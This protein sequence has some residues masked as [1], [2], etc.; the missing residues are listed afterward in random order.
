MRVKILISLGILAGL[1]ILVS[2]AF[3]EKSSHRAEQTK[4][5]SQL[6][7]RRQLWESAYRHRGTQIVYPAAPE[8]IAAGYR[9]YYKSVQRNR[10]AEWFKRYVHSDAE[11]PADSLDRKPLSLVG[12]IGSNRV[13]QQLLPQLPIKL[14]EHGFRFRGQDYTAPDDILYLLN[15][16]P[17][18][19]TQLLTV[20]TGNSDS[21]ILAFLNKSS[22][23][24]RQMSEYYVAQQGRVV[25]FGFF[26]DEGEQAWQPE[27]A[28]EYDLHGHEKQ[29]EMTLHFSYVTHGKNVSE[30]EIAALA[31]RN[32][33]NLFKLMRRLRVPKAKVDLL[34]RLAVHL[35]DSAEE[36][37]MF[38]SNTDLRHLDAARH[39]AH[40][41]WLPDFRGDDFFAEANWFIQQLLGE[42]KSAALREGLTTAMSE[43]WRGCGY[44]GWAARLVQ[45][46]NAPPLAE[47]FEA[48]V[49]EAE[50]DLVRQPLL[51]SFTAYLL[52]KFGAEEFTKLYQTWPESGLPSNF[53]QNEKWENLIAAWQEKMR[54]TAATPL[55]H[56]QPPP[57][58]ASDFHRGFCYAH[59]G[60]QIYNGYL[61]HKSRE[62]LENLA[63]LGVNAI[64]VTPFGYLRQANQPDFLGRSNGPSG[65]SDE[66]LIIA[67]SF[68]KA[69]NIRV[70]L[71]PHIWV[72]RGWPGDI[73]MPAP[74]AWKIFFDRYERWMRGYAM[75]A[76]IYDFD[77]L[78]VGVELAQT[79]VGH[80]PEWRSMIKSLRELYS[81][82]MVYAANWGQEFENLAFWEA[83]EAIGIDCYYPL[84][85]EENPTD[86]ELKAGA[87]QVVK[88]IHA[89]SKKFNKPVLLT[90][91]GFCSMPQTWK[92]PHQD[93][94]GAPV[95]LEAQ[96]RCYEAISQ[97]FK[98]SMEKDGDWLAGIYWWKWPTMLEDGGPQD[99]QFTPNGK[100]AA[101]VVA[102]WY[103]LGVNAEATTGQ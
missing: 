34:P 31:E 70:M 81:G 77:V 45:T 9:E 74:A 68:A 102:R 10:D 23:R 100:P 49:W 50:S 80:A 29:A 57:I 17:Q 5:N 7:T 4:S 28:R 64:S 67:Q 101:E 15:P 39:E 89:V 96:R 46:Q 93:S 18:N 19:P 88:K 72:G 3:Q 71:K 25:R 48:N 47:L 58:T 91:I 84:S 24:L 97:A 8:T 79:T 38:T 26:Q 98:N 75:L 69:H 56:T 36:K 42:S 22:R 40:L 92:S 99:N 73:N 43:H 30:A 59:E 44:S 12:A 2:F 85:E 41:L 61:G 53:P 82:P 65:E 37:G 11:Y 14:L 33:E 6:P 62:A 86:A 16:N 13:L 35:W 87:E 95:D 54:A 83:L 78:C 21:A 63:T 27:A 55:R 66:S 51:G 90:E 20:L 32:E 1:V 52:E 94:R 103:K 76:E 60:Y